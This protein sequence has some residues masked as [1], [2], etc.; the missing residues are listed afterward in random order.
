M[1]KFL[2]IDHLALFKEMPCEAEWLP[3]HHLARFILAAVTQM[4]LSAF[5]GAYAGKGSQAYPPAMLLALF[6]YGYVNRTF[7]S[8]KIEAATYDYRESPG[9]KDKQ[10]PPAVSR[11]VK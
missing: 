4:D 5:E 7:T 11:I 10:R 6:I 1:S 9:N 3:E 8:R 2:V